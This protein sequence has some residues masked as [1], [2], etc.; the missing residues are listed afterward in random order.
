MLQMNTTD[1]SLINKKR[2]F[3]VKELQDLSGR[4]RLVYFKENKASAIKIS[5]PESEVIFR[6]LVDENKS[7][8]IPLDDEN[9]TE[10]NSTKASKLE[11]L[12]SSPQSLKQFNHIINNLRRE[13]AIIK[14]EQGYNILYLTF[15][16]LKWRESESSVV[17]ESPIILVPV[18]ILKNSKT[19]EFEIRLLDEDI[20][21]N[22]VL[23]TKLKKEFEIDLPDIP[24]E[25]QSNDLRNFYDEIGK[26]F[27]IKHWAV[28]YTTAISK[29]NFLN[30]IIINDYET[31]AEKF[32]NNTLV[33]KLCGVNF[34]ETEFDAT[35]N[36]ISIEE[37]DYKVHPL[38]VNQILD[39]DSSQ[40]SAIEAAKNGISFILQ[41]PPGTGKSQTIANIISEF[42][43]AGKKVL[44][45]SQ[46]MA[47]LE[48]VK[49]RLDDR[50]LGEFCLEVH[51]HKMDKR[52]IIQ[53]LYQSFDKEITY[54]NKPILE[55]DKKLLTTIRS[56]LNGFVNE[57][58]KPF[59]KLN[60]SMYTAQGEFSK[61][62][63]EENVRVNIERVTQL[64]KTELNS[65]LILVEQTSQA[66]DS[67]QKLHLSKWKGFGKSSLTLFE[68][69]KIEA[70]LVEILAITE[71]IHTLL[72]NYLSDSTKINEL[73]IY[74]EFQILN[75]INKFSL[76]IFSEDYLEV[77]NNFKNYQNIFRIF[78]L[79]YWSDLKRISKLINSGNM[80]DP[81]LILEYSPMIR[82]II[83]NKSIKNSILTI[84]E[85]HKI[86]QLILKTQKIYEL[87]INLQSNFKSNEGP[88][89]LRYFEQMTFME[90]SKEFNQ[91]IESSNHIE[92]W[93]KL[94]QK[95]DECA[96]MNIDKFV[97]ALIENNIPATKWRNTFLRRF[98]SQFIDTIKSESKILNEFSGD[99]HTILIDRFVTLEH[100]LIENSKY[101][102]YGEL[103]ERRTNQDWVQAKSTEPNIL[104]KEFNKKRSLMS[105]RKLFATIPNLITNLKPCL[106]MSPYTVSQLLSPDIYEFDLAIF[107]EAS[108]IPPE[109]AVGTILRSKQLIIAGDRQQLPPTSFFWISD[110]EDLDEEESNVKFESVLNAFDGV[111]FPN[112]TLNWHYRS[113]DESLIAFSNYNFYEN[114]LLTFPSPSIKDE[115]IGVKFIKVENGI[116]R[117]GEGARF[118]TIEAEKVVELIEHILGEY[119]DLSLGVVAFS[120]SQRDA[121]EDYLEK[122]RRENSSLNSKLSVDRKEPLFIKNLE[123]VQGDERD[124]IILSIGYGKDETGKLSL[125]FGPI[126]KAGGERRLNVAITR[127]RYSLKVVSSMDP[128][129]IGIGRADSKG[130]KLLKSFLEVAK[131][132]AKLTYKDQI[133]NFDA[134]FDSPFEESVFNELVKRGLTV[135]K[136]VGV[137]DYRID[138][139]II[140]SSQPGKYLLGI[141]CDGASY[142]SSATARD[143]DRLRQEVL[144][145]LGWNI[146]RIWSRDWFQNKQREIEKILQ[147]LDDNNLSKK[148][149]LTGK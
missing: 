58:H 26:L 121:I 146:H 108:Q 89:S 59:F 6:L 102:I 13:S 114:K 82:S 17:I 54:K 91:L 2:E 134:D 113:K 149:I 68:M 12:R 23:R 107:D 15:G 135:E 44:F 76:E 128:E 127:A 141:E 48:V 118:N 39:A 20:L 56:E 97:N 77:I 112:R 115:N 46:K 11:Y 120:A 8:R 34:D 73:N 25:L 67:S 29:F 51:S 66:F 87:V 55:E 144:E 47:A 131:Y 65:Q 53:N 98:Y 140:D 139:A 116:F 41:G 31:N 123:N 63:D 104:K 105:L 40:Q 21:V 125:N 138:L 36:S 143:R 60:C 101:E 142:H 110:D 28:E 22:P 14:E 81:S 33:R 69:E 57:L 109:Y 88:R 111:N 130:A 129:D 124:I 70:A 100:S 132:G 95:I 75:I 80:A 4:N 92:E 10:S 79:Q 103:Q 27:V 16:M 32:P 74:A 30:L 19:Q 133:S 37:L 148:K 3:W 38:H 83:E 9:T 86:N 145:N 7:L 24:T 117:R 137:S 49:K 5:S 119:P 64:S 35:Q 52:K 147:K 85:K 1:L 42:L 61:I 96:K 72:S 43:M 106:M 84:S 122:R 78:N 18:E 50:L 62:E 99:S 93:V 126:N 136:Q 71:D 90:I 45:V 94:N